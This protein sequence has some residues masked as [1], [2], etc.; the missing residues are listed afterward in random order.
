[1]KPPPWILLHVPFIFASCVLFL[2]AAGAGILFLVQE[3]RIKSHDVDAITS[4]LP[5]LETLDRFIYR[6]IA[7]SFP[8]LTLGILLGG[9]WAIFTRKSYWGYDPS[10]TLSFLTWTIYAIYL[11]TR[12]TLGWRGRR[13][14]YLA[15]IGFAV[16]LTALVTLPF[17]S[18]LHAQG[19]R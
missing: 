17:L 15:L 2:L 11:V 7:I 3:H 9:H 5:P 18:P 12:W 10:E 6:M 13:S 4:R 16:I 8:L 19:G 1:M 14:T